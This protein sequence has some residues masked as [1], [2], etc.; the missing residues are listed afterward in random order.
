MLDLFLCRLCGGV[1]W[2]IGISASD[3][4]LRSTRSMINIACALFPGDR[5]TSLRIAP[6]CINC[7][8]KRRQR[9]WTVSH[10]E[11]GWGMCHCSWT[12]DPVSTS[13]CRRIRLS[14]SRTHQ[15]VNVQWEMSP[16]RH[17]G[18]GVWWSRLKG[19]NRLQHVH[20]FSSSTL[21][22]LSSKIADLKAII[23]RNKA[24]IYENKH[25]STADTLSPT[26]QSRGIGHTSEEAMIRKR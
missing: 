19:V 21:T 4:G 6:S 12:Q 9:S 2:T 3:I 7:R 11:R 5:L 13:C 15:H 25:V 22:L 26:R 20:V 8:A 16:L 17:R 24:P 14:W 10:A 23:D 1:E 18:C